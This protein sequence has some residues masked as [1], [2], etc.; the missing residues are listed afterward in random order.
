[1]ISYFLK[2]KFFPNIFSIKIGEDISST[3]CFGLCVYEQYNLT[4]LD[5]WLPTLSQND[6]I[7]VDQF[8]CMYM[9]DMFMKLITG[10]SCREPF[11][12]PLFSYEK[13]GAELGP[14][15]LIRRKIGYHNCISHGE[16]TWDYISTDV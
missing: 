10:R 16:G 11:V 13:N 2:D 3:W 15:N 8:N 1:M 6:S 12:H 9:L 4:S 7:I 14:N 5:N